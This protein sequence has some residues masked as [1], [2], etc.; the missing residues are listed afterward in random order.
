MI[1][2]RY[3][4]ECLIAARTAIEQAMEALDSVYEMRKDHVG[5]VDRLMQ[6]HTELTEEIGVVGK[7]MLGGE[8]ST[9]G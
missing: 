8:E 4:Y 5:M 1:G 9:S 2:D 3:N 7:R 6:I